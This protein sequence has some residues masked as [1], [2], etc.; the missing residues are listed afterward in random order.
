MEMMDRSLHE[1]YKLVYD[2]L[3]LRIPEP[4]V[5]R[6]AESVSHDTL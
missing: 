2:K 3:H 4:V 6:M 5:G 1:V